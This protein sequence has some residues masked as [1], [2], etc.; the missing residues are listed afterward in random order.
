M[1]VVQVFAYYYTDILHK[2]YKTKRSSNALK[3]KHGLI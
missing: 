2:I 3:K 1:D